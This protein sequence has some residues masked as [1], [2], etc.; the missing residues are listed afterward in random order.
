[1]LIVAVR[2]LILYA[3]V[4]FAIR[5]MGKSELSKMSPFQLVIVFMI[6]ELAA[7]PIDDPDVSLINGIVAI[8]TLMFLQIVCSFLSVRSE[9]FKNFIS[10]KPAI[11]IEKGKLNIKEL[12]RLRITTT[13]LMEQLRLENCP[14]ICNVQ[15]AIMESNGQLSVIQKADVRPVTPQD[16]HLSS[17]D[18]MIPLILIADGI[19]YHRNLIMLNLKETDFQHR[20]AEKGITSYKSVFLAVSDEKKQIHVYMKDNRGQCFT[21]EVRL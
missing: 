10:G 8:F 2:T 12:K 14:S 7:I 5:L 4:L 11:L 17:V 3:L 19:V 15:Y 9:G 16:L 1:M 18:G 13:D 21:Q 6:A 20:L